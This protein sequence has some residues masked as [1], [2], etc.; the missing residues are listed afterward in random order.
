MESTLSYDSSE[1]ELPRSRK[2]SGYFLL[3]VMGLV[4]MGVALQ[5]PWSGSDEKLG[6][7]VTAEVTLLG[8]H[9]VVRKSASNMND[10]E[11]KRFVDAIKTMM[12]VS[13]MP[14]KGRYAQTGTSE[15]FRIAS[16]HGWPGDSFS[17]EM[18][19]AHHL[20]SF[21]SWHRAYLKEFEAALRRADVLNDNDGFIGVPY[22]DF[23][24]YYYVPEVIKEHF[25]SEYTG[26]LR[27]QMEKMPEDA[28]HSKK[29][30]LDGDYSGL[31]TDDEA[32]EYLSKIGELMQMV[33]AETEHVNFVKKL[34]FPAHGIVHNGAG[35]NS[36]VPNFLIT[37]FHPL[38]W[39][40]HSNVER[41]YDAYLQRT[42]QAAEQFENNNRDL[43]EKTLW[44]FTWEQ[45]DLYPTDT[46]SDSYI[47]YVYDNYDNAKPSG[48]GVSPSHGS[49][50]ISKVSPKA[51]GHS[52]CTFLAF[53][54][55][56]DKKDST[57]WQPPQGWSLPKDFSPSGARF[58]VW[59]LSI[60]TRDM[61]ASLY[62]A[63]IRAARL[64]TWR[65]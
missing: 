39:L 25:S 26:T 54:R 51:L 30:I 5:V 40:L 58:V 1:S 46:F 63:S 52:P 65:C 9:P 33:L 13:K 35:F 49:V 38:F 50:Y 27:A 64:K 29:M 47:D 41:Y 7:E 17:G 36:I 31:A 18:M 19:C 61:T 23:A 57:T 6:A 4:L 62:L 42:P 59:V 12:D 56:K 28:E 15:F 16:Y 10:Q 20:E 14:A 32:D 44:P 22:W 8:S 45:K 55:Q 2:T 60:R 48:G 43:F 37:A 24:K 21:G 53:V 34:E 3:P 11:A